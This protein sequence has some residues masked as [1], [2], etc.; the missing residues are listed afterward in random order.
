M[1]AQSWI[2]ANTKEMSLDPSNPIN[3]QPI[4]LSSKC[5][6]VLELFMANVKR[7]I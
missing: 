5:V 1:L 7:V 3:N 2:R 4:N 6:K